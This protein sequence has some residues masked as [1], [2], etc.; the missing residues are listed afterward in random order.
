MFRLKAGLQKLEQKINSLH[1]DQNFLSR[2]QIKDF[3]DTVIEV[4]GKAVFDLWKNTHD[5]L[6][7][8]LE[9]KDENCVRDS[10]Q[11]F[12]EHLKELLYQSPFANRTFEKPR[13]YAGD[14]EMMNLIYNNH[15]MGNTLFAR[16]I[17]R[18]FLMCPEPQAVRNR[19]S[20]LLERIL[21]RVRES[22]GPIKILSV[23]SGPA[24]EVQRLVSELGQED[25]SRIELH[26]LDQDEASLKYA[27]RKIH[28]VTSSLAVDF[29]PTLI[30]SSIK[31]IIS[32]GL[33]DQDYDIIYSAGLFD[34]FTD[35]VAH[36]AGK[37]LLD[38][39]KESGSLIIGNFNISTPNQFTM[40]LVFD[41]NLKYRSND[42]LDRIFNYT[43][44]SLKIES[45]PENV[46]LFCVLKRS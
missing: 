39:L 2:N 21:N 10:F 20:Y 5:V 46:N 40:S 42:D 3:E 4:T 6:K 17:E 13:G 28:Q 24:V 26:L 32:A 18:S 44:S 30:Q 12:R 37:A 15:D 22:S 14:Y 38:G 31:E 8:S 35:P 45:E 7:K 43:E 29:V 36:V 34:Y 23:A 19:A 9:G 33:P 16:C 11:F 41:W 27:Q 25:L 1:T